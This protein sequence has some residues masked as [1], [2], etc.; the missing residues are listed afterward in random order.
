MYAD[1]AKTIHN[2]DMMMAT[3]LHRVLNKLFGKIVFE[4]QVHFRIKK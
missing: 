2:H 4:K 3:S 1:I